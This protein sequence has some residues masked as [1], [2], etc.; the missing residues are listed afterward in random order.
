MTFDLLQV[1]VILG[2]GGVLGLLVLLLDLLLPLGVH[3]DLRGHEGGHGDELEVGV[4][5]ELAGEPEEGLELYL[6]QGK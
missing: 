4:A 2:Q 5:D 6:T 1:L 3:L